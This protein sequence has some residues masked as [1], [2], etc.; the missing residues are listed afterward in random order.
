MVDRRAGLVLALLGAA[1]WTAR[2]TSPPRSV[3]VDG[4]RPAVAGAETASRS[5]SL[6]VARNERAQLAAADDEV[7]PSPWRQDRVAFTPAGHGNA[8]AIARRVGGTLARNARESGQAEVWVPEGEDAAE[9]IAQLRAD[10][11]VRLAGPVGRVAGRGKAKA[12]TKSTTPRNG[13]RD[14][15][16]LTQAEA[17]V[18]L[19]LDVE[20]AAAAALDEAEALLAE[21]EA[22][23]DAGDPDA[24]DALALAFAELDAAQLAWEAADADLAEALYQVAREET[25]IAERERRRQLRQVQWYLTRIQHPRWGLESELA[26]AAADTDLSDWTVAV[27]DTGVAHRAAPSLASCPIVA[28]HDFVNGD[29]DAG[30]DHQHGTHIASLIASDG[31]VVGIAAGVGLMPVK[32]LDEDNQGTETDLVDGILWA[33]DHGADVINMSLSFSGG[34]LPSAALLDALERAHGAGIVMIAA[35]GNDGSDEVSWPAASPHVI[36]VGSSTLD[37]SDR[38]LRGAAY[39]NASLQVD[40]TAPGGLVGVDED[41][42][43]VDDGILGETIAYQDPSQAG[44][45]LYA[46]TSQAAALVSGAAVHLLDA[47]LTADQ[48]K[49]ALQHGANDDLGRDT[50]QSGY[51]AGSLDLTKALGKQSDR[52]LD[53]HGA[54]HAAVMPYLRQLDATTVQATAVI[55]V[56]DDTGE[57]ADRRAA[58]V[59]VRGSQ[60]ANL[61]CQTDQKGTCTLTLPGLVMADG[62]DPGLAW[63]WRVDAIVTHDI[64]DRPSP[65][66]FGTDGFAVLDAAAQAHPELSDGLLAIHWPAGDDAALGELAEAFVAT[67]AG[68]GLATSPLGLLFTRPAI[69]GIATEQIYDVDLDGTGL[70]TSS[71]GFARFR[72]LTLNGSGLATSPLG[73]LLGGSRLRLVALDG[74]GLAT[75]PLGFHARHVFLPRAVVGGTGLATSPLGLSSNRLFLRSGRLSG[76]GMA[77]SPLGIRLSTG[78]WRTASGHSGAT[79]LAATGLI[80]V[81]GP[82]ALDAG[83]SDS[84]APF[85]EAVLDTYSYVYAAP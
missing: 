15:D 68:T 16:G 85:Q 84:G 73:L 1:L 49:G 2:D 4:A 5:A 33:V 45:W 40:V 60:I 51:G 71:L 17:L 83:A 55:T 37:G 64:A 69:A 27:L 43:G 3:G 32:V 53:E 24:A 57:P 10:P 70:A 26:E 6:P 12:K 63:Q 38:S 13:T 67:D 14:A 54:H 72:T 47:G 35:A 52:H 65:V 81:A 77:T 42:D 41:G 75:S 31:E 28:P 61:E 82:S 58:L 46:G 11:D 21:A 44:L 79:L 23:E 56:L 29:S 36:A 48:V 50:W 22:M 59:S 76:T 30:D 66:L 25:Q 19:S 8:A 39:T 62:V 18:S 20:A 34:Y 80:G 74:T 9:L 78:G 7:T